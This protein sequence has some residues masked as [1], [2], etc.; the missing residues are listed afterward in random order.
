M[1]PWH[2]YG[3]WASLFS[4]SL[5]V[6]YRN[7]CSEDTKG[8]SRMV[9]PRWCSCRVGT[10]SIMRQ[11]TLGTNQDGTWVGGGHADVQPCLWFL[12]LLF[13]GR[14]M[15]SSEWYYPFSV[16]MYISLPSTPIFSHVSFFFFTTTFHAFYWFGSRL[17]KSPAYIRKPCSGPGTSLIEQSLHMDP[18]DFPS[19]PPP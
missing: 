15:I 7:E 12:S 3:T 18:L 5:G 11:Q 14:T 8:Q 6:W 16:Q 10:A 19:M 17:S 1:L 2:F 9:V 13:P 4:I